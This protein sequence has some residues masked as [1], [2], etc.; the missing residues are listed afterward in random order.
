MDPLQSNATGESSQRRL[1]ALVRYAA[2]ALTAG[3]LALAGLWL[4]RS[5]LP[6]PLLDTLRSGRAMLVER[7][8]GPAQRAR[9]NEA[10]FRAVNA[11]WPTISELPAP[12]VRWD[13]ER[14][15]SSVEPIGGA[16]RASRPVLIFTDYRCGFC[17]A[18]VA[19]LEL[20]IRQSVNQRHCFIETPLL[21]PR[22]HDLARV[23]IAR[24]LS[25][26][27]YLEVRRSTFAGEGAPAP[28]PTLQ[29][30][31][32]ADSLIMRNLDL[33]RAVG[34]GGIPAYAL[35]DRVVF[36]DLQSEGSN[37]P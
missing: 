15:L 24:A 13:G 27:G 22:S 31:Q 18:D 14:V 26:E 12:C 4:F 7:L 21:G 10:V 37:P 9:Q 20:R 25:G 30:Q 1:P 5:Y 36:G 33:A 3:L 16:D 32:E 8:T 11:A 2:L 28:A 19:D 17:R 35:E 29:A 23:A 6:Q 34:I